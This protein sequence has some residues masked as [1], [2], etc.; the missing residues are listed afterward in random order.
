[1]T[2]MAV[3][4]RQGEILQFRDI[5]HLVYQAVFD[6]A[7]RVKEKVAVCIPIDS[8]KGLASVFRQDTIE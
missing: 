1:M 2:L 7:P 4:G 3:S 5:H 8:L 6:R